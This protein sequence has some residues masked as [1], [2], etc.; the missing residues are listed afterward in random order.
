M[1]SSWTK[2][3]VRLVMLAFALS[4]ALSS[5]SIVATAESQKA[6]DFSAPTVQG[7]NLTLSS[8]KGRII[9][10]EFMHFCP[11]SEKDNDPQ[12]NELVKFDRLGKAQVITVLYHTTGDPTPQELL[13]RYNI[14][15]PL[16]DDTEGFEIFDSYK[17][18]WV[19]STGMGFLNPT[20]LLLDGS[21]SIVGIYHTHQSAAALADKVERLESG[22]WGKTEGD[23][24]TQSSMFIGMFVLGIITSASPCSI[25][26]LVS[27]L[28]YTVSASEKGH[29]G[30][31]SKMKTGKVNAQTKGK[32]LMV[33]GFVIGLSFTFGMSLIFLVVGLL[34]SSVSAIIAW[35]PVFYLAAGIVLVI[36]GINTMYSLSDALGSLLAGLRRA[37]KP[38]GDL[39]INFE[40]VKKALISITDR[41]AYL[42]AFLLG[43]LFTLGWAP[44]AISLILPAL[45]LLLTAKLPL[46]TGGLMLFVFGIGHGIPAIPLCMATSEARGKLGQS[47]A[48]AGK[49]LTN[50]FGMIIIVLGF[51]M[52]LRPFG[53]LLW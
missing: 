47:Y 15:W 33:T 21:Q 42:G 16:V 49:W 38:E 35:A 14:T 27:M 24:S 36:L 9:V 8:Y 39:K 19:D 50:A 32:S 44:C 34:I 25:V 23:I 46:I 13:A 53:L 11:C 5:A 37:R 4:S 22:N 45:I 3:K 20:I 30:K 7:G 10:L 26:L 17:R 43:I 6:P 28:G 52:A 31:K 51:L 29:A 12:L 48:N 40:K 2:R 18:Y 41:S 1:T